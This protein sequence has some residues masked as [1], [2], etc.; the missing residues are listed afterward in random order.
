MSIN[1]DDLTIGQA[2]QIAN[3]VAPL[4]TARTSDGR[5]YGWQIVVLER[6]FVYVGMVTIADGYLRIIAAR[7]IRRWGTKRGLGELV[8]GPLPNTALDAAGVVIAPLHAL[9]HL[10]GVDGAKWQMS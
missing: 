4:L 3:Q 8:D 10:I 5:D 9:I 2:K 1:L 7:N 6:G